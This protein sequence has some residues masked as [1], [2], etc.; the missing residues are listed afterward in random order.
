[1]GERE[2]Y[3]E[4]GLKNKVRVKLDGN[5]LDREFPNRGAALKYLKDHEGLTRQEIN[6]RVRIAA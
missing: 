5:W 1:M 3:N 2:R 6:Q 4:Y